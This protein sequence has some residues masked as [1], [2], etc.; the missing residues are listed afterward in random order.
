MTEQ[1]N[2]ILAIAVS[3]A[4]LVGWDHFYVPK[5]PPAPPSQEQSVPTPSATPGSQSP[6]AT[7]PPQVP[8]Q[9]VAAAPSVSPEEM[10]A[11]AL[12][13]APRIHIAT[14]SLSGSLSPIGAR[15]DDLSLVNYHET[16][17]PSS[18]EILSALEKLRH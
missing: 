9:P 7:T 15:L 12:A 18:P 6:A 17:D 5:H 11:K 4:I 10:R 16:P 13:A 2:L 3:V 14:P 8:A 1:K